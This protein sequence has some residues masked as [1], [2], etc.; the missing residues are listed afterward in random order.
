MRLIIFLE[1]TIL[2]I[3]NLLQNKDE[4]LLERIPRNT[5]EYK[6]MTE[7]MKEYKEITKITREYK[8]MTEITKEYKGITKIT[9]EYKVMTEIMKEY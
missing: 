4:E 9:R 7:I 1:Q 8:V 6:V 2:G 5:R 3:E